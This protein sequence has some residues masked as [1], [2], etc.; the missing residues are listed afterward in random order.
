MKNILNPFLFSYPN[1]VI[2][3]YYGKPLETF[4]DGNKIFLHN[5]IFSSLQWILSK[6]KLKAINP[7]LNV[8]VGST[9][10]NKLKVLA[11]FSKGGVEVNLSNLPISFTFIKGE[12]GLIEIIRTNSKGIANGLIITI[13]PLQKLQI[14]TFRLSFPNRKLVR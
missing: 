8:K 7:K 1:D 9:L 4:Y 13:S 2:Q 3:N 14:I 10:I 12:G 11:T 5:E 6:I